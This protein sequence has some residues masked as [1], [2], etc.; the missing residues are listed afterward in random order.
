VLMIALLWQFVSICFA[1]DVIAAAPVES[2]IGTTQENKGRQLS[3][4]A[5]AKPVLLEARPERI[6]KGGSQPESI[7]FNDV[8]Y[9]QLASITTQHAGPMTSRPWPVR[10]GYWLIYRALLI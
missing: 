9:C 10:R 4:V 8:R 2:H 7:S 6:A 1:V 3:M 5:G